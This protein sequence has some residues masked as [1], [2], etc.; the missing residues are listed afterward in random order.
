M[1]THK[2]YF[3]MANPKDNIN[4]KNVESLIKAQQNANNDLETSVYGSTNNV[5]Q[6][7]LKTKSLVNDTVSALI[8]QDAES[9][10][11][12][13]VGT[14]EKYYN[15]QGDKSKEA[16]RQIKESLTNMDS[17]ND[18]YKY[19]SEINATISK[20]EDLNI[21]VNL[22]P[23]LGDAINT[24]VDTILSP[25]DFT[26]PVVLNLTSAGEA[27][28]DDDKFNKETREILKDYKYNK[29]LKEIVRRT[30]IQ[31]KHYV[32]AIPYSRAFQNILEDKNVKLEKLKMKGLSESFKPEKE[33]DTVISL[34][35]SSLVSELNEA[36][37]TAKGEAISNS[38]IETADSVVFTEG[39]NSIIDTESL[40]EALK[41]TNTRIKGK[42]IKSIQ[43]KLN[44]NGKVSTDGFA[45]IG[46]VGPGKET[47]TSAL[48]GC[49]IKQLDIRKLI[50]LE[51]EDICL[52]YYYIDSDDSQ[53]ALRKSF[54][55]QQWAQQIKKKA[56]ENNIANTVEK[57]YDNLARLIL[58]RMDKKFLEKNAHVKEE[59]Y[60]I[61]R[62]HQVLH[63]RNAVKV[64]YL[65][66]DEVHKFEISDGKSV[67]ENVL[68]FAKLYLGLFLANIMMRISRSNDIRAYYVSTGLTADVSGAINHAINE[69]KKDSRSLMHMN[70]VPRMIGTVTKFTD[71][72]IP[73]DKDG[74]KPI[75]FDIIQGQDIQVK[76]ELL[77]MLEEIIVS[78]TGVPSVL[79]N[80]SNDVDFAKTLTT[81]NS[82]YL[83]RSMGWQLDL[84]EPNTGLIKAI[85]STEMD[86]KDSEIQSLNATFQPPTNL[87]LQNA[88]DEI[89][90]ARDLAN[91]ISSAIV[92]D[93]AQG[94]DNQRIL[95]IVNLEVM[96]KYTPSVPWAEFEEIYKQAKVQLQT[97]KAEAKVTA[98]EGGDDTAGY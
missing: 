44:V 69:V 15:S 84:N 7:A 21:I 28:K 2:P 26:K 43:D 70:H 63:N 24:I 91:T 3:F 11:S 27:L 65:R 46:G 71:M 42:N 39:I 68:F 51:I 34:L 60:G 25:D 33:G 95:D 79:L 1:K 75:E 78:G 23:Q 82:K 52:G 14:L 89:N 37:G 66:P 83:R 47:D 77:E 87:I 13:I 67:L 73:M 72:F 31:G 64:T 6:D 16:F 48:K 88:L 19:Y 76:D 38:I 92:G 81:L 94:D 5:E 22:I 98:E 4:I 55:P 61:L 32:S 86:D 40:S 8:Q 50:P 12:D 54:N 53:Q 96:K 80:A 41:D 20:H 62:Y 59:V 93:N 30:V 97:E 74:K 45:A 9:M 35:E 18:I 57:A 10:N 90:N 29:E 17:A 58:Q 36:F 49:I 56:N 85:L